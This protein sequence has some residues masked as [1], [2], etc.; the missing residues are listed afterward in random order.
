MRIFINSIG[1]ILFNNMQIMLL[2][3]RKKIY[4]YILWACDTIE[5]FFDTIWYLIL[6]LVSYVKQ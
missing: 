6:E 1:I 2:K 5:D 3:R 4:I